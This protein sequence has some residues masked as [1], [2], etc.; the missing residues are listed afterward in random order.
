MIKDFYNAFSIF[1]TR[2]YYLAKLK[3]FSNPVIGNVT[4][5]LS[6][7]RDDSIRHLRLDRSTFERDIRRFMKKKKQKNSHTARVL[8]SPD[9]S[10]SVIDIGISTV[11]MVRKNSNFDKMVNRN[12]NSALKE[13]LCLLMVRFFIAKV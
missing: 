9:S 5:K 10:W 4:S 11:P 12:F 3:Q 1:G 13:V 2:A 6:K 8:A 7:I